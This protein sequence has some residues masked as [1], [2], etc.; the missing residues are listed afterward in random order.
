MKRYLVHCIA[1]G[2][3]LATTLIPSITL[4]QPTLLSGVLEKDTTLTSI[5]NPWQVDSDLVV[6]ADITLT[7]TA[8][9][10]INFNS[11][12]T[13]I[14]EE[15]GKLVAA[16]TAEN[17]I[18]FTNL[19]EKKWNGVR[20]LNTRKDNYLGYV[21]MLYGDAGS[22]ML[23]VDNSKLL[24]ESMTWVTPNKTVLEVDH[25][26]LLVRNSVFPSVQSVEVVHG[27]TLA[28]DDYLILDGNTFGST[29]DYN[30]VIDFSNCKRPGPILQAYNNIFL[31]GGDDGLDLDGCDAHIEGNLFT[32]FHRDPDNPG[33]SNAVSTGERY[34]RTSDITLVRNIFINN[35]HSV[36]LKEDCFLQAENNVF[37]NS[38]EAVVNFS[39]WPLRDVAPG[40]GATFIGNI[41]WNNTA[42][43][44]NQFAQ[45]GDTDPVIQVHQCL[46]DS[47]FHYLGSGNIDA[48]PLF[49]D[50]G[51]DFHL[52]DGSPAI[53]A[54]PNGL[55]MGRYV[56]AGVSISGE[57]DSVTTET[58]AALT[59]GGPGIT[60][61]RYNINNTADNWS[62]EIS[63]QDHPV[64]Q[65]SG[66]QPGTTYTVYVKG[67]N[68][69][70]TWQQQ[71]EFATSKSWIVDTLNTGIDH[72]KPQQLPAQ[73]RLYQNTPNPFNPVTTIT[74]ELA[75]DGQVLLEIFNLYGQKVAVLAEGDYKQ[76]AHLITWN[77][78]PYA[79]G[80][81]YCRLLHG[82]YNLSQ[83]MLLLK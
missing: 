5:H 47:A 66:L 15:D 41:F 67:K 10:E 42:P 4:A 54:G 19:P 55:D 65:L 7:I 21:D 46:I 24:I 70:G 12:A 35:D 34:S 37:V 36:L 50:A 20:F 43:F 49:V 9:V 63:I 64:L 61:Y 28:D 16:G 29:T 75:Q 3:I 40:K 51:N 81:Y 58:T 74:F 27:Q 82:N 76:G 62:D 80:V 25:P 32:N 45:S 69:A 38:T 6:P 73:C 57:P 33:T 53:G 2:L 31:G 22:Y 8:G 1:A 56:P 60:H 26:Q 52:Q 39:E 30:D 83:K 59:I 17:R 72:K 78:A 44:E 77:A 18:R 79:G 23:L 11:A 48:D 14:I 13:L 68:S 71:P